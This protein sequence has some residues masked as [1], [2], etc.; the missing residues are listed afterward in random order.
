MSYEH[1][2]G[3]F[4]WNA[5]SFKDPSDYMI[6]LT[7]DDRGEIL[8]AL[9]ALERRGRL[10]PAHALTKRD[11]GFG[12]LGEKLDRGYEEVRS[13]KGFV[14]V[15][16]LPLEGMSLDRFT[17]CAWGVGTHFGR[18][19]SQNA[20]GEL[21]TSV[22]DAST[23]DA[24]P[25]MYRSNLELRPHSDITAMIA[26]ACWH[27]SASGGA[28]IIVSGVTVHDE[29]RSRAPQLLGPLYRGYHYHRLGEEGPG[30][31]TA[32]PYR[33]PVF[34]NR[35]GQVSCRYQRA[36]IAAGMRERGEALE[37]LDIEAL[38]LFDQVA[39]APKNR[40]AFFLERGDMIVI[41]NYTVMH[42]RTRFTNFP[43]P[44]RQR[45]LVRFWFDAEGF[46]DVPREFNLFGENGIPRQEGRRATFDFRKLYRDDPVATGGVP[47]LKITDGEAART[48]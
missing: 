40:L 33:M 6:E 20:Q 17:A 46:R 4:A 37:P 9:G 5:S 11:F 43:D 3:S 18:A 41:N 1:S 8:A 12:G 13:G 21:V 22:I 39:S 25:R 2:S 28:S 42:A 7:S 15:R 35:N 44:E 16:G 38:N 26:L 48:R 31:E 29:I 32:T 24:T 47:D 36:G 34:A 19:L 10:A 14:V 30:E 45:R 27:Q 23:E